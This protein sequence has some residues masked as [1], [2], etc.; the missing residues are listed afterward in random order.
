MNTE[1]MPSEAL[2]R[3]KRQ[4]EFPDQPKTSPT[5]IDRATLMS[6]SDYY[7]DQINKTETSIIITNLTHF[8]TYS[9]SI[10]VCRMPEVDE[11]P[12]T[13][14]L[15]SYDSGDQVQ[16]FMNSSMDNIPIVTAEEM[17]NNSS[18]TDIKVVW[19]PPENPNGLLLSYQI[20][21]K[22]VDA[23]AL[24]YYICVPGDKNSYIIPK[25]APGNYS[26]EVRAKSFAQDGNYTSARNVIIKE[27]STTSMW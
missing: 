20:R 22:K 12:G 25:V 1:E 17:A 11:Q 23:D 15:C 3:A 6:S 9:V 5:L 19:T 10:R 7:N 18:S 27:P 13:E 21:Y 16:T 4:S 24:Y 26:I 14:A 8:R 2:S